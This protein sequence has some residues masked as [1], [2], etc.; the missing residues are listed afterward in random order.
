[1]NREDLVGL[2]ARVFAIYL[3]VVGV[4][5]VSSSISLNYM[6]AGL[7][8]VYAISLAVVFI[9]LVSAVLWVFPLSIARKL[10]PT[11]R[12][13]DAGDSLN[14]STALGLGLTLFGIWLFAHALNDL[15]YW[16][17]YWTKTREVGG[18]LENVSPG[19]YAQM[20]S[21]SFRFL[22]SLVLIAGSRG[23]KRAILRLRFGDRADGF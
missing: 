7:V 21:A 8:P 18:T 14:S 15:V 19:E 3:L 6:E 13:R 22:L 1:M 23:I 12:D 10:L 5:F 11:T 17:F 2:A 20:A 9:L 4:Q 16:A